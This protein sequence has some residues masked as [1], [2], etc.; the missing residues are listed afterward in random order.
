ML[1]HSCHKQNKFSD[2]SD[3][4]KLSEIHLNSNKS[5]FI[6]L[7]MRFIAG[8]LQGTD[9]QSILDDI[10]KLKIIVKGHERRIK[11]LEEKLSVYDNMHQNDF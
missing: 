1:A 5:Y 4:L 8:I 3:N 7:I 10:R 2:N 6:Y 11:S 9:I